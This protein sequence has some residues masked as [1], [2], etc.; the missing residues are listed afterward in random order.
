MISTIEMICEWYPRSASA[1][2][3]RL[4]AHVLRDVLLSKVAQQLELPERAKAEH[5]DY[6]GISANLCTS[7]GEGSL[8]W[9]KGAIFLMATFW[10]VGRWMAEQTTP[11]A[12]SP[13]I[14]CTAYL[15]P[16]EKRTKGG[17][18]GQLPP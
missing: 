5:C 15:D 8:E 4:R 9:S 13:I 2:S 7:G 17:T 3:Q 1:P 6:A 18:R 16:T 11:Y 14:S 12:P 10:P